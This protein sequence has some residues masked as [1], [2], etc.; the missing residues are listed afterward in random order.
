MRNGIIVATIV[1]IVVGGSALLLAGGDSKSGGSQAKAGG[2]SLLKSGAKVDIADFKYKPPNFSVKAGSK[3]TFTNQ[4]TAPHTATSKTAGAFD[5]GK[6][7]KGQSKAV[8]F[9]KAGDFKYYCQFHAF[10]T[11]DV[12]VVK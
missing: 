9:S 2:G 7:T 5:T 4:D 6:L 8:T 12:K 10:M 11:G 3:I 1:A